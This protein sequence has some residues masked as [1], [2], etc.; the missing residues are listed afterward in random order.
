MI[1]RMARPTIRTGSANGQFRQRVPSDLIGILRGTNFVATLPPATIE[2]DSITVSCTIGDTVTFSLRTSDPSLLRQRHASAQQQVNAFFKATRDGPCDLTYKQISSVCGLLY[3]RLTAEHEALPL[4]ESGLDTVADIVADVSRFIAFGTTEGERRAFK[5]MRKWIDLE[6]FMIA[7]RSSYGITL[8]SKS[9]RDLLEA[10]PETLHRAYDLLAKRSSGDYS[11]DATR[12]RYHPLQQLQ[13]ASSSGHAPSVT[14]FDHLFERWKGGNVHA[15]STLSTWRGYLNRFKEFVEHSDP[16]GVTRADALRW[17]DALIS[18]GRQKIDTTYLAALRRLYGY[19]L[20]NAET[21][22]VKVNPFEGVKAKQKAK[23]GQGRLPF[24]TSEVSRILQAARAEESA[25]LRWIPWLQAST[26][27]RVA[28]LAQLWGAM[29]VEVDGIPCITLTP[30]PDGGSL[31]N[32]ISERTI[33]IHPTILADGFLSFVQKRGK[34]PLFYGGPKA[35]PSVRKSEEQKHPSKG[36]SNRLGAWVRG[37]GIVDPRKAPN[38]S[39]RHWVKTELAR[40]GCSDRLADAIQGHSQKTEA[41]TYYHA[42]PRDMLAAMSKIDLE[43]AVKRGSSDS[44]HGQT[45]KSF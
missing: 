20:E 18:E 8:S 3:D 7:L 10:V 11:S 34:G 27:A 19:S 43:A 28:E 26:G 44:R 23:A 37:L 21:T 9:R 39:W 33:P 38:H 30:A 4:D 5:K 32:D 29:V 13:T 1:L 31:K 24:T 36:V 16:H 35:K 41:G 17:K 45:I 25:Y 12:D 2:A 15:A 40:T 6:E 14:T 22:G 42:E